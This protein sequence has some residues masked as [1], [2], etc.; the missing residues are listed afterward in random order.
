MKNAVL[1]TMLAAML[2]AAPARAQEYDDNDEL[3]S[4]E[5]EKGEALILINIQDGD[6]TPLEGVLVSVK[7]GQFRKPFTRI[8]DKEGKVKLVVGNDYVYE[9]RF[10]SLDV[11][12]NEHVEKFDIPAEEDLRYSLYM[13]YKEPQTKEFILDGV[14]FNSGKA[15]LKAPSYKPLG[16]LLEYLKMKKSVKI[17]LG[18]HTDNVGS[19]EDNQ[20]LSEARANT[21]R[22]WLIKKGIAADRITAVGYGE[23]QP[24]D[25]N[26]TE[27]GRKKNRRTVVRITSD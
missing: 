3:F 13:T 2:P 24:V 11:S 4:V 7:Q 12:Q 16:V 8:S 23:T 20:K 17:E 22:S 15:T 14:F 26:D 18:G 1:L 5:L 19:D 6:G 9:I 21:V 27:A 25:S 10:L